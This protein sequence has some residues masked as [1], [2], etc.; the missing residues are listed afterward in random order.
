M[1]KIILFCVLGFAFCGTTMAADNS[2]IAVVDVKFILQKSQVGV[3][4][5]EQMGKKQD[6]Y[7]KDVETQQKKLSSAKD[8]LS[9]QRSV[10]SPEAY[11]QK[12]QDFEKDL[13]ALQSNMRNKKKSLDKAFTSGLES[14]QDKILEIVADIAKEKKYKVVMP[15][16]SVLLLQDSSL[17]ITQQVLRELDSKMTTVDLK[18]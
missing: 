17:D 5:Q 3:S 15:R 14:V 8:E 18:F 12:R 6:E 16:S 11:A 1:K 7:K 10:L 9:R 2:S 13:S 4:I